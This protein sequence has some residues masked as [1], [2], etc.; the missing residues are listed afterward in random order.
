MRLFEIDEKYTDL[1]EQELAS[2]IEK[3]SEPLKTT[4]AGR[5]KIY[6]GMRDIGSKG[7]VNG[8]MIRR[9]SANTQNYYTL[10]MGIL[11]SWKG[12]PQRD[13]SLICS[14]SELMA[15]GYGRMTGRTKYIVIP[16]ENQQI[17]V[18]SDK[19][20]WTSF[21]FSRHVSGK[22]SNSLP[23]FNGEFSD[24]ADELGIGTPPY[25]SKELMSEFIGKMETA[26]YQR[27]EPINDNVLYPY[28]KKHG[29]KF[30][31]NTILDPAKNGFKLFSSYSD[32]TTADVFVDN[33][34]FLTGKCLVLQDHV[35]KGI[36][37]M[38]RNAA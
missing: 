17:A 33:E 5:N 20:F 36:V 10:I 15:S 16:L 30:G 34:V 21:D 38:M 29:V 22:M 14:S 12:W 23:G 26:I 6:R 37:Q 28:F 25:K 1:S 8:H 18:S 4:I 7:I 35:Y 32:Y 13:N 27:E 11:P 3:Y 24:L 9:S 2:I 19:D 31:L